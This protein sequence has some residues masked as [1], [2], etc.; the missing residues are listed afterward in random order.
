MLVMS[1]FHSWV[2]EKV[3]ILP[4]FFKD[5]FVEYE[6]LSGWIFFLSV[7][8]LPHCLF[9]WIIFKKDSVA[10]LIFPLL[11]VICLF[12]L[13][14]V[15]IYSYHWFWVIW[16]CSDNV[17]SFMCLGLG[18]HWTFGISEFIVFIKFRKLWAII[19]SNI[20]LL[21]STLEDS[22]YSLQRQLEVFPQFP[23]LPLPPHSNFSLSVTLDSFCFYA[24]KFQ[25]FTFARCNLSLI[26]CSVFFH[27]RHH[28]FH[29]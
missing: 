7:K 9:T 20:F 8:I 18:V 5:I 10:I 29:R 28:S 12:S 21:P 22:E 2:S 15:K 1:C 11:Y 3:H 25:I 6:M 19:S 27:L 24:F 26:L 4:S 16:V 23:V 13:T 17:I 14:I